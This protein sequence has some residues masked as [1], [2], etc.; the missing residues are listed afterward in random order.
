MYKLNKEKT[1][2]IIVHST[3]TREYHLLTQEG[4]TFTVRCEEGW[5]YSN[6]LTTLSEDGTSVEES[7][8][9]V[10]DSDSLDEFLNTDEFYENVKREQTTL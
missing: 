9:Q 4:L 3:E 1:Q 7:F 5:E 8:R 2:G 6:Y 10:W